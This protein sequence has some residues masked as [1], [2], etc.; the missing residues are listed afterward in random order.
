MTPRFLVCGAAPGAAAGNATSTQVLCD[1]LEEFGAV[2][3]LTHEIRPI[4][5]WHEKQTPKQRTISIGVQPA[6]VHGEALIS[7]RLFRGRLRMAR[8]DVIWAVN[9][10]YAGVAKGARVPYL[11]WEATPIRD[12]LKAMSVQ[13]VR[14]AGRG[15]GFGLLAHRASLNLGER[16][17]RRVL[18]AATKVYAMSEYTRSRVLEIHRLPRSH[19]DVLLHPPSRSFLEALR[20]QGGVAARA[21]PP[22]S[23]APRLLFVGRADDPRKNLPLLFEACRLLDAGG[24]P[25]RLTVVGPHTPRWARAQSL[26]PNVV[27][28]DLVALDRLVELYLS[29]DVLVLSS[30]QEGFGIVVAEALHAGLPVVTTPCG[31]PEDVLRRSGGGVIAGFAAKELAG[32]ISLLTSNSDAWQ[33][34]SR[35]G[36]QFAATELSFERLTA[37]VRRIASGMI[38]DGNKALSSPARIIAAL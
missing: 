16:L 15:S 36:A 38:G 8:Y 1:A 27:L 4:P 17:E 22:S 19:V 24:F 5:G 35:G 29:H 23:T 10:R 3:V 25:V 13:E 20:R 28:L 31:G 37:N 11:I 7:G 21:L 34:A 14:R 2:D 26:P 6:L 30:R 9:S 12:E 32:A 18:A 33:R